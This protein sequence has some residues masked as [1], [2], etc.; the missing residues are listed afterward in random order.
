MS[1][2]AG[3][4]DMALNW[5]QVAHWLADTRRKKYRAGLLLHIEFCGCIPGSPSGVVM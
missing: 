5:V 3:T 4:S 1:S 2:G